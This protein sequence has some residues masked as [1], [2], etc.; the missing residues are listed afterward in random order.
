MTPMAL[1][2]TNFASAVVSIC[3]ISSTVLSSP[4]PSRPKVIWSKS[5]C[6]ESITIATAIL[7]HMSLFD[8][9]AALNRLQRNGS[10]EKTLVTD[11]L[12]PFG[13][14]IFGNERNS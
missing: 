11:F 6:R 7:S 14:L 12:N 5:S 8:V 2:L 13:L 3:C 9:M 10:S 4:R 1:L